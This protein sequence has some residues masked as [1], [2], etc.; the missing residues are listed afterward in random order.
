MHIC[1]TAV[2]TLADSE[3]FP[4]DWL[5]KHRWNKGKK[6][7]VMKMPDGSTITFLTVGG[8]TSC[9]VPSRQKKTGDVVIDMPEAKS[10]GGKVK[11]KK[12]TKEEVEDDDE[13][14][15]GRDSNPLLSPRMKRKAPPAKPTSKR[16]KS[17]GTLAAAVKQERER[18]ESAEHD[19][20]EYEDEGKAKSLGK[21]RKAPQPSPASTKTS[22]KADN[23]TST[24]HTPL[25]RSK[26]VSRG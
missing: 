4:E 1:N 24:N 5:F 12:G 23:S 3:Q 2:S 22:P 16:V 15:D 6:D 11:G 20:S 19:P 13:S 18:E 7:K 8:R 25:G 9:I 26:R 21:K 10:G 14:G 17:N